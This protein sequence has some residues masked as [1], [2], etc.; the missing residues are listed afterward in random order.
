M[1]LYEFACETC[2]ITFEKL[3]QKVNDDPE[4]CPKCGKP[5][6]KIISKTASMAYNWSQWTR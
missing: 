1:P 6:E 3:H 4:P 5:A 2:K